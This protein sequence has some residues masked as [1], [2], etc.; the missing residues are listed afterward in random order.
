[1]T[2]ACWRSA[3]AIPTLPWPKI[4]KQ[5]PKKRLRT[6]SRSTYCAARKRI[7]ACAAVN[8][9]VLMAR[10]YDAAHAMSKLLVRSHVADAE[11]CVLRVTPESAGWR[12]VGFEAYRLCDGMRLARS[13]P[14][15]ET[16][17]VIMA[18]RVDASAGG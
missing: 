11:G 13:S 8:L 3:C 1:M 4:P 10:L 14:D 18:G 5:P 12:Y 6:P 17:I 2:S 15:R 9:T 16:C 7:N